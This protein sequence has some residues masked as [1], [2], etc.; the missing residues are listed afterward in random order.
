[1]I[2]LF[3]YPCIPLSFL[4]EEKM[5]LHL[6]HVGVCHTWHYYLV[7]IKMK[8]IWKLIDLILSFICLNSV[9]VAVVVHKDDQIKVYTFGPYY[10]RFFSKSLWP[11]NVWTVTIFKLWQKLTVSI[12]CTVLILAF[13]VAHTFLWKE[14]SF[15]PTKL[16]IIKNNKIWFSLKIEYIFCL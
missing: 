10:I 15:L 4:T 9:V 12:R 2:T 8:N 16:R 1:M 7:W 11:N 5:K 13:Y 6:V 14:Y 3:L